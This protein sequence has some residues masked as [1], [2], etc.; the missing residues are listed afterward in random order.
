MVSLAA[1]GLQS[2][3]VTKSGAT[4]VWGSTADA[5]ITTLL[6][7]AVNSMATSV[8]SYNATGESFGAAG[9]D[10]L[11][12]VRQT[13]GLA[14]S[15]TSGSILKSDGSLWAWGENTLGQL[16]ANIADTNAKVDLDGLKQVYYAQDTSEHLRFQQVDVVTENED[17]TKGQTKTSYH[18][19]RELTLYLD[20]MDT[21][22]IQPEMVVL[23]RTDT[24]SLLTQAVW[25]PGLYASGESAEENKK[26]RL[27][28]LSVN[29][30]LVT[31]S[32]DVP[33]LGKINR[34]TVT[35]GTYTYILVY[36][37]EKN[38]DGD[39]VD[40]GRTG[41]LNLAFFN[42]S[43]GNKGTRGEGSPVAQVATPTVT[44]GERY[45]Y[46]L[47]ADGTVWAWGR[48]A[49]ND[50]LHSGNTANQ[51]VLLPS[52]VRN[53]GDPTGYLTGVKQM[54]S[55]DNF[56]LVLTVDNRVYGWGANGNGQLGNG[57]TNAVTAIDMT[58]NFV[59]MTR[60]ASNGANGD[61]FRLGDETLRDLSYDTYFSYEGGYQPAGMLPYGTYGNSVDSTPE[62]GPVYHD[63]TYRY[64]Y[65]N[66][67][68]KI[69]AGD[70]H[71]V[72]LMQD[73]TVYAW[74]ASTSGQLGRDK[75]SYDR[76]VLGFRLKTRNVADVAAGG[77]HTLLLKTDGTVWAFGD[78]AYGQIGVGDT[79]HHND[80]VQV[81]KADG[82][83]LTDIVSIEAGTSFS[84]ALDVHGNAWIWGRNNGSLLYATSV[85]VAEKVY[86]IGAFHDG[87]SL[88]V[89]EDT[90][91]DTDRSGM[92]Y[93]WDTVSDQ[94]LPQLVKNG[95]AFIST[96]ADDTAEDLLTGVL[97][98]G[99]SG[100]HTMVL[101]EDGSVYGMDD[102]DNTTDDGILGDKDGLTSRNGTT[103]PSHRVD[104]AD[105]TGLVRI[106]G[107]EAGL[108]PLEYTIAGGAAKNVTEDGEM[109]DIVMLN[110]QTLY[111]D[112]V[113]T[114][115]PYYFNLSHYRSRVP[116]IF[117][118][119]DY[120]VEILNGEELVILNPDG[121]IT[122]KED[123]SGTVKLI[124][125]D[126]RV[127]TANGQYKELGVV[128]LT[129]NR[130]SGDNVTDN[131]FTRPM[132]AAGDDFTLALTADGRVYSWGIPD[133]GVLGREITAASPAN[134]AG[135]RDHR[136]G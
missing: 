130:A 129:V 112:R 7:D 3:A 33:G 121:S 76:F 100:T 85:D 120:D 24:F 46:A 113:L 34:N 72:A 136:R 114:D 28:F 36:E 43:I 119:A 9:D 73:G 84:L 45:T 6:P 109:A 135:H 20:T 80:P 97:R 44:A 116:E 75:M 10:G 63:N 5:G 61:S 21:F 127:Q 22:Y 15:K 39:W 65:T 83:P 93:R 89:R 88:V 101:L 118:T 57:N 38:A 62:G 70:N 92:L 122:A 8:T 110:G 115:D 60:A 16:G 12:K 79:V 50:L 26:R 40:T 134:M 1:G 102:E 41:Q 123:V 59:R 2:G 125:R 96:A 51:T 103:A 90:G 11:A 82:E 77:N 117:S 108:I 78:N 47:R 81:M 4:Y 95:E 53:S 25:F 52:Q 31:F 64:T 48:S 66:E 13:Y 32:D 99:V 35:N 27:R 106:G 37:Q 98:A 107:Q 104:R 111:I 71:A 56:I 74:G 132:V 131:S 126:K 67:V 69:A 91:A 124:L 86:G 42:S 17:G 14:F 68:A 23:E 18:A 58:N 87:A 30:G 55:G 54:V 128:A 94:E 133:N 19:P 29:P 105:D 49:G